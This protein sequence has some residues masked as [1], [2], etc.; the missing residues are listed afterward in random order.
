MDIPVWFKLKGIFES[1]NTQLETQRSQ[2]E[3]FSAALQQIKEQAGEQQE[4]LRQELRAAQEKIQQ[5]ADENMQLQQLAGKWEEYGSAVQ[6]IQSEQQT[7]QAGVNDRFYHTDIDS[8]EKEMHFVDLAFPGN[9]DRYK[10][11][12][13]THTGES[14]VIVGNG[15]SLRMEDLERLQQAGVATFAS[16]RIYVSFAETNWR[17]TYYICQDFKMLQH[18]WEEMCR[19]EDCTCLFP[20][21]IVY[22]FHKST[23]Q[24]KAIFYPFKYKN[25]YPIWFS[26]NQDK[27]IHEGMTVTFS[28]M[29]IAAF[30]GFSKIYL[31]GVDFD[32][33]FIINEQGQAVLDRS[34][35]THFS[36][37]YYDKNEVIYQPNLVASLQAYQAAKEYADT[38]DIEIYN[39][40]RGGKLEVFPRANFDEVF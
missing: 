37:D 6:R 11:L 23:K 1:I 31:L 40:T 13:A 17:P 33:P 35:Q 30:M 32:Y 2:Q 8:L 27:A 12:A 16:N 15:P 10:A 20:H 26:C 18:H 3:S 14:C 24:E 5:L 7:I 19:L 38:H 25:P 4:Q 9:F 39:A 21:S 29:Q 36:S 28:A 22:E 34:Q